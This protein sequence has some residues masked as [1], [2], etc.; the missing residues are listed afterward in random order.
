[1]T[2][3]MKPTGPGSR[4]A[5]PRQLTDEQ[6]RWLHELLQDPD[7]W[8][9]RSNWESFLRTGDRGT[10]VHTD[11]LTR[12]QRIAAL[13]WLRQQRH[14]LYLALEGEPHAPAGWLESLPLVQRLEELI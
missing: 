7:T 14:V 13:E 10:L 11:E 3:T 2:T 9:L 4:R 6:R 1:M 12:D 8:V 5:V